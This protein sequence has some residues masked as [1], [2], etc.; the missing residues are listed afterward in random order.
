M[1]KTITDDKRKKKVE[2]ATSILQ[3][4]GFPK[5]Q[6][7]ERS[8]LTLLDLKRSDVWSKCSNKLVRGTSEI[9]EFLNTNYEQDYKPNTRET[10][11][12]DT[13]DP[14]EIAGLIA[15]KI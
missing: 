1:T 13:I 7:N 14:F 15:K 11:R 12:K 4:L 3:Q 8:A 5:E 9:I 6:L 10:F 2:E